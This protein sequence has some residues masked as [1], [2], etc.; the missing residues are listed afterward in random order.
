MCRMKVE[1]FDV[2]RE[3]ADAMA[4]EPVC[5]NAERS[6]VDGSVTIRISACWRDVGI[7]VG[8]GGKRFG[9][10]VG[11]VRAAGL[12]DG[13]GAELRD[14]VRTSGES[15]A[16]PAW[17]PDGVWPS[18]ALP[19]MNRLLNA[20]LPGATARQQIESNGV[21]F[22]IDMVGDYAMARAAGVR[23]DLSTLFDAIGK[24]HGYGVVVMFGDVT[25]EEWAKQPST[26]DGRFARHHD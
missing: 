14:Y 18:T 1:S 21:T 8:K 4:I 9:A 6:S 7:L 12:V 13:H 22:F 10:M 11:L 17:K 2:F 24:K 26:P 15:D 16:Q 20:V 19:L 25:R 23:R 5:Y 3:L